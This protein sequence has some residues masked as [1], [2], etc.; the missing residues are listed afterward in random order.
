MK[1]VRLLLTL[2]LLAPSLLT[3]HEADE[4]WDWRWSWD[5]SCCKATL[6]LQSLAFALAYCLKEA[7]VPF[8]VCVC[9]CFL[10]VRACR[11]ANLL[12]RGLVLEYPT[13]ITKC[14]LAMGLLQL[15][16][17]VDSSAQIPKSCLC[18]RWHLQPRTL[19]RPSSTNFAACYDRLFF[20]RRPPGYIMAIYGSS[21]TL[22]RELARSRTIPITWPDFHICEK[23]KQK[24]F[25]RGVC[26]RCCPMHEPDNNSARSQ[27][28]MPWHP[29][30][31]GRLNLQMYRGK[32]LN[33][34]YPG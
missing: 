29:H 6:L 4:S 9:A 11:S 12:M 23:K 21:D 22:S 31:K 1:A 8:P 7:C 19:R 30:M 10:Y 15:R 5:C 25:C 33:I 32:S 24:L 34:N 28:T 27:I 14:H 2:L 3:R 17:H 13:R 26:E 20:G 18:G 16:V